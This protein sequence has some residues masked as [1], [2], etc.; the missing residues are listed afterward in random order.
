ML[1]CEYHPIYI[2]DNT[3]GDLIL[4]QDILRGDSDD[5]QYKLPLLVD[6]RLNHEGKPVVADFLIK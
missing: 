4:I 3:Y 5:Y 2:V 6:L 1:S